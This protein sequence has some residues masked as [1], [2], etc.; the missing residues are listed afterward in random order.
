MKKAG[1]SQDAPAFFAYVDVASADQDFFAVFFTTFFWP[2]DFFV[3]T[4]FLLPV[5]PDAF[6]LP[7]PRCD[8]PLNFFVEDEE[9]STRG[10]SGGTGSFQLNASIC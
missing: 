9:R 4:A 3:A 2:L 10:L 8:L 6:A 1:A 7:L 5:R